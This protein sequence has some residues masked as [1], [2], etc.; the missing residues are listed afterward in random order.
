MDTDTR[1]RVIDLARQIVDA[2]EKSLAVDRDADNYDEYV[3]TIG[4]NAFTSA[5]ESS[6]ELA[7]LLGAPFTKYTAEIAFMGDLGAIMEVF[8][9][10]IEKLVKAYA[11]DTDQPRF[12]AV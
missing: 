3:D 1:K 7:D 8:T 5:V 12:R 4:L 6:W 2:H 11:D 10:S 9:D